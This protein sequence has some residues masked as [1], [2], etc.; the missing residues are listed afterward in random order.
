MAILTKSGREAM[1]KAVGK[2]PIFMGWGKGGPEWNKAMPSE[3]VNATGLIDAV[4][5]RRASEIKFCKPDQKG[6][7]IIPSGRFAVSEATTNHLYLKFVFDFDDAK[8]K[9][10]QEIGVF[11]ATKAKEGLPEGQFYFLP[12]Q[13]EN[14]G[15]LLLLEH[16]KPLHREIG[17]RETFEFVVSF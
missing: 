8:G 17:V 13:I 11:I 10:I 2:Q 15:D 9:T 1:A 3:S 6:A 4:G 16:R 14:K 12:D 7:I 5:Y